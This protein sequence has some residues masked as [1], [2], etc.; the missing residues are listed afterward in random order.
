L[1]THELVNE[2]EFEHGYP[3]EVY[4]DMD[5]VDALVEAKV[6]SDGEETWARRIINLGG[7]IGESGLNLGEVFQ[8]NGEKYRVLE[9]EF[10]LRIEQEK[11]PVSGKKSNKTKVKR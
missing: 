3:D 1:E 8:L 9:G 2:D 10:G 5:E 11:K 4:E 6:S 7:D